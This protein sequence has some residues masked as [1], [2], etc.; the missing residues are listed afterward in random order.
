MQPREGKGMGAHPRE[1]SDV[2]SSL[3]NTHP[4]FS[5]AELA[6]QGNISNRQV[7]CLTGD[8]IK[9]NHKKNQSGRPVK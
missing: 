9:N 2:P 8:R 4:L 7:Y 3:R 5:F 1:G 6:A